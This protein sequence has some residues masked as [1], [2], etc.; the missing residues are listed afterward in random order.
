MAFLCRR[1]RTYYIGFTDPATGRERRLSLKTTNRAHAEDMVADYNAAERMDILGVPGRNKPNNPTLS[2]LFDDYL[3]FCRIHRKPRTYRDTEMHIRLFLRPVLGG[4]RVLAL[5]GHIE[6]L[7]GQMKE[8]GYDVRTINLRLETL[9]KV[10]RRAVDNKDIPAMPCPI[11]LLRMPRRLPRYALPDQLAAW[12]RHLDHEH[13]LRAILS[14]NTG[15][16]DQDFQHIRLPEGFDRQNRTVRYIR[17]KTGREIVIPLNQVSM[18]IMDILTT[19]NQSPRLFRHVSARRAYRTA[20]RRAG[21][22]ITPH[23]L[24]HTFATQALSRG[25]PRAHVQDLLGHDDPASTAVY[26]WVLPDYLRAAVDAVGEGQDWDTLLRQDDPQRHTS[27]T[28]KKAT[29]ESVA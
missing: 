12:L 13:R 14:V 4:V 21:V 23:M 16:T 28:N 27:G 22:R 19:D 1:G 24:R 26:A 15:I 18:R 3:P 20:S 8:Q 2:D 25:I 7:I 6:D 5:P 29:P 17:P 11:K 9:R 10:L